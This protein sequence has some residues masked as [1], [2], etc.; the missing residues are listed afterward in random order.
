VTTAA[1]E[2]VS[3]GATR[4]GVIGRLGQPIGHSVQRVVERGPTGCIAYAAER[5]DANRAGDMRSFCFR[6][7]R[8]AGQRDW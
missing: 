8:L 6:G 1:S 5:F 2:G 3:P 7:G 4:A